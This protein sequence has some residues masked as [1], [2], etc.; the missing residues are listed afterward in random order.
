MKANNSVVKQTEQANQTLLK[1]T[2]KGN[3]RLLKQMEHTYCAICSH[4]LMCSEEEDYMH[5]PY[6]CTLI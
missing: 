2:K 1:P 4:D 6:V 5:Q 3:E